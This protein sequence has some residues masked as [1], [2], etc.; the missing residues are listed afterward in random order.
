MNFTSPF[1]V[2][3]SDKKD[4]LLIN[5]KNRNLFMSSIT[6]NIL[7]TDKLEMIKSIPK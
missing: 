4:Q 3:D 1:I 7:E 6:G 5:V 2:S